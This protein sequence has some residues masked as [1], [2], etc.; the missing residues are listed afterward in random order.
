[1]TELVEQFSKYPIVQV[2]YVV[3]DAIAAA[4]KHSALYGSGPFLVTEHMSLSDIRYRSAP[5]TLDITTVYG[6]WGPVVVHFVQQNVPG[7]SIFTE[8]HPG[9]NEGFHAVVV[10]ADDVD[11]AIARFAAHGFHVALSA[12]IGTFRDRGHLGIPLVYL[13]ALERYGHFIKLLPGTEAV[14]G[15]LTRLREAHD[16]FTGGDPI[17]F[18]RE[19][20]GEGAPLDRQPIQ[21]IEY[22]VRDVE[23]A[24]REHSATFGSGPFYV[25]PK[26]PL[27]NVT[28]R[29]AP[30]QLDITAA[31]GQWGPLLV[32]FVQQNTP[33]G[34]VFSEFHPG[35]TEGFH[36]VGVLVEDDEQVVRRFQAAGLEPAL[37]AENRRL[38]AERSFPFIQLDALDD[39]GHFVK[40]LP[41]SEPVLSTLSR[42]RKAHETFHG[43]IPV[44]TWPGTD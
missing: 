43:D 5:G 31:F 15:L 13:D 25:T 36:A 6:Q 4:R 7:D 27:T 37:S 24:A 17:G 22:V 38:G 1:M 16:N 8:L 39:Y 21:Q 35:G 32:H 34:S 19:D 23:A 3:P 30:T 42:V 28:Y 11:A 12:R 44:S 26:V 18:D 10:V 33:G 2:E 41:R 14:L 9:G 20:V 40:L 29:G